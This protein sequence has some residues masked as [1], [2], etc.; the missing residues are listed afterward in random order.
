MADVKREDGYYWV[1]LGSEW[2]VAYYCEPQD[3]WEHEG[4]LGIYDSYWCEIDERRIT[5][6]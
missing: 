4:V 3:A 5:R 6:D 2:G 1:R